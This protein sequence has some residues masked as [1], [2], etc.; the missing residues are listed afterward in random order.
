MVSR[1]ARCHVRGGLAHPQSEVRICA[2]QQEILEPLV[3][4]FHMSTNIRCS[5]F[6]SGELF[7]TK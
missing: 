1:A 6:L 4:N 2:K 3:V 5:L 7:N